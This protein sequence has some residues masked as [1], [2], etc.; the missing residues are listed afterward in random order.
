MP[1]LS[2]ALSPTL[3]ADTAPSLL[4]T[5]LDADVP[6]Y[7]L[8][9][10]IPA[11]YRGDQFA[12]DSCHDPSKLIAK[13]VVDQDFLFSRYERLFR[14]KS[15]AASY[16]LVPWMGVPAVNS[17]TD[18]WTPLTGDYALTVSPDPRGAPSLAGAA[19]GANARKLRLVSCTPKITAI[20]DSQKGLSDESL[21]EAADVS[22]FAPQPVTITIDGGTHQESVEYVEIKE[23]LPD[24]SFGKTV[25]KL[26]IV[27]LEMLTQKAFLIDITDCGTSYQFDRR[28]LT[29]T[30]VVLESDGA[31]DYLHGDLMDQANTFGF[32]QIGI[33]L[34]FEGSAVDMYDTDDNRMFLD[35]NGFPKSQTV[36]K[37]ADPPQPAKPLTSNEK[38]TDAIMELMAIIDHVEDS[39]A[40]G[41]QSKYSRLY[42]FISPE[43]TTGSPGF[44]RSSSQLR[45]SNPNKSTA[46]YTTEIPPNVN[47]SKWLK[48][49]SLQPAV[50][51]AREADQISYKTVVH[52]SAHSLF[53]SHS[54]DYKIKTQK[55]PVV[56][57][58]DDIIEAHKHLRIYLLNEFVSD[59]EHNFD[60]KRI[61]IEDFTTGVGRTLFDDIVDMGMMPAIDSFINNA[62]FF[63]HPPSP[64]QPAVYRRSS[65]SMV[66]TDIQFFISLNDI[67]KLTKR[68]TNN[69]MDY[70]Y[71]NEGHNPNDFE[72]YLS[73]VI[74]H[75]DRFQWELMRRVLRRR[76][77]LEF[78]G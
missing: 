3:A 46:R 10:D 26:R 21:W 51:S 36:T 56:E 77:E 58:Y 20:W 43:I 34:Q 72:Y 54:F 41:A 17:A 29:S 7:G 8:V 49:S 18:Q 48:P 69:V 44:S 67:V 13:D 65:Y 28:P 14:Y 33:S 42:I 11:T 35:A 39:A 71:I 78:N 15:I 1:L 59:F 73:R 45:T 16:Y 30:P 55:L 19:A 68:S 50:L 47:L 12:F 27:F 66:T 75:F 64:L 74:V 22:R 31:P 40:P 63:G 24:G 76:Q 61:C 57:Y 23:V 25:G 60:S 5:L 38:Y 62:I 6:D 9:F 32:K 4:T 52:E 37:S 53:V 70:Q 2:A